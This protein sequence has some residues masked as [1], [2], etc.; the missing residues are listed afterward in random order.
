MKLIFINRYFYPDHSATSQMLSDLAFALAARDEEVVVITSR[1]LYES[2][3][4]PLPSVESINGVRVIRVWT[5]RFG[6]ANL[7]GRAVDYLTFYL[8]AGV[9][10]MLAASR[11][12]IVIAKTDPP[13]LSVIAHPMCR[14]R[15]ALLVN[16]LQDLFPEVA[17]AVG[18]R[19]GGSR[20]GRVLHRA[21]RA[22][23]NWSLK[24]AAMNVAIGEGMA[25]RIRLL[26]VA[27]ARVCVIPNWADGDLIRPLDRAGNVLS[28]QWGLE[29]AFVVGYSGNLGR[30]HDHA[31]IIDAMS[32][33]EKPCATVGAAIPSRE[34][35][36]DGSAAER[37]I[38]DRPIVWLFVG[39]GTGFEA[40]RREAEQ[41]H[42]SSVVFKPYQP[43][44]NL[45]ASLGLA[46]VHLVSL[47]PELEGLV[48]PSKYYGIAAAGR[49]AIFI[50]A[51]EGE[52]GRA[53]ACSEAG[54]TVPQGDAAALAGAIMTLAKHPERRRHMGANARLAF[55][56][57]FDKRRAVER[58]QTAL[59]N[60]ARGASPSG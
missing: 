29:G 56:R 17:E 37:G 48:V 54:L 11:G 23:R 58:W 30:V 42:L 28:G 26:G 8:S 1:Q 3:S 51:A 43:R 57:A 47:R 21:F 7:I 19:G 24:G 59:R 45:A 16:W 25:E 36:R 49:P 14:L 9:A 34:E 27:Q 44:S 38:G 20:L 15:G 35:S 5:T 22:L 46:D 10:V 6:R 2:R 55:E 4:L 39:G 31:T 53:L 52:I 40:L 33:L 60:V 12:D 18:G 50:G 32:C 13:M 41:R